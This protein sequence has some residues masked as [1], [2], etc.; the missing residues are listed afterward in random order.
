MFDF[1]P[2]RRASRPLPADGIRAVSRSGPFGTRW[3][4]NRVYGI[5]ENEL[6][7]FVKIA[8]KN[9][10]RRGQVLWF[11]AN[12][13]KVSAQIQG[14]TSQPYR[15][16]IEFHEVPADLLEKYF[17]THIDQYSTV[18]SKGLT[19]EVFQG[20]QDAGIDLCETPFLKSCSCDCPEWDT[21]CKHAAAV[22][23][24][25]IEHLDKKV[26]DLFKIRG[27]DLKKLFSSDDKAVDI[28]DI[29]FINMWESRPELTL[30]SAFGPES[31]EA[32]EWLRQVY[33]K[34]T[35]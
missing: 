24:L 3:W 15:C 11:A 21:Y 10:A 25:L 14:S 18:L 7:G 32:M 29:D 19:E 31:A 34:L 35:N 6:S 12:K 33:A 5:I 4:A 20:L 13:G 16:T 17:V 1:D 22:L 23:Y 27:I 8:G 2:P 28:N 26:L 9:Y 30:R